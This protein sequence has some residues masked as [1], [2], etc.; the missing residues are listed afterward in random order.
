MQCVL[1][2]SKLGPA[3]YFIFSRGIFRVLPTIK[4][5]AFGEDSK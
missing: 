2:D 4:D 5:E 1:T 3:V